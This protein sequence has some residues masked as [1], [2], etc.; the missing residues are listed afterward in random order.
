M[1]KSKNIEENNI[2]ELNN[3]LPQQNNHIFSKHILIKANAFRS[4]EKKLVQILASKN[5][6][7]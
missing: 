2:I 1:K 7:S 6:I 4:V 5:Y 3:Q